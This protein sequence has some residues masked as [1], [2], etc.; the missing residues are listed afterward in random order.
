MAEISIDTSSSG[1]EPETTL[2]METQPTVEQEDRNFI[3]KV[4][5]FVQTLPNVDV[6]RLK[7][8]TNTTPPSR[9]VLMLKNLPQ[10]DEKIFKLLLHLHLD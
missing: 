8:Q 9:Y 4:V 6:D 3:S 1:N 7:V 5:Q 10:M 2:V